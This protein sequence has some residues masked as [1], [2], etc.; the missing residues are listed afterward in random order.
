MP[1]AVAI[2]LDLFLTVVFAAIGRRNHGESSALV[3]VAHTAWPFLVGVLVGWALLAVARRTHA[4]ASL[5]S[6]C[7]VWLSTVIVG[8]I[9]R[10]LTGSGTALPFIIVATLFTGA[11]MLGWRA[12]A[13]VARRKRPTTTA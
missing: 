12:I 11:V 8:M 1:V 13:L 2:V 6:G 9:L 3:G 7:V 5:S 4:G 10:Q